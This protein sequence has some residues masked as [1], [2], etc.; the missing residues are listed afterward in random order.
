VLCDAEDCRVSEDDN[1]L[2]GSAD[3][4]ED[5]DPDADADGCEDVLSREV[6]DDVDASDK[7]L[8]V[9]KLSPKLDATETDTGTAALDGA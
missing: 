7:V 9:V 8:D 1:R 5:E 2:D 6:N 4:D 3:E